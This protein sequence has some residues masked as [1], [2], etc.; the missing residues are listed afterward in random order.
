MLTAIETNNETLMDIINIPQ[1]FQTKGAML[2]KCL[3]GAFAARIQKMAGGMGRWLRHIMSKS[4]MIRLM[5]CP[6]YSN[7]TWHVKS[8]QFAKFIYVI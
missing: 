3:Q 1:A 8:F 5:I 6:T 7:V 4:V 2:R